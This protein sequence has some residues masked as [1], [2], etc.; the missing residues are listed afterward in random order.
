[1]KI[2]LIGLDTSH[3]IAF[4]EILNKEHKVVCGFPG[5]VP[6]FD[7]SINRVEAFTKRLR[8][9]FGVAIVD[10]PAAVAEQSDIV[11]ITS[12][13]GRAH[14]RFFEEIA[15]FKKPTFIDKPFTTTVADAQ[16]I[17]DLA[18]KNNIP[19]MSSSGLRYIDNLQEAITGEPVVGIDV[20]G[21][22]Q[23]QPTQP[24]LFWYG[25]HGIEMVVAAL[26]VGC[27]RVH[28]TTNHDVDLVV[29]QWADGRVA[30]YRGSR[31]GHNQ[32][33]GVV[34]REKSRCLID[35]TNTKRP[36]VVCMLEAII[37]SL[38]AG[39]SDVPVEQT[40]EIVRIICAANQS[41]ETGQP[42]TL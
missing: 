16:A 32:F 38:S 25:I 30:T 26:G 33:G 10:S 29:M 14:R 35:Y 9:E 17:I 22:M 8:D 36:P 13:D 7:A 20:Y 18:A 15:R 41:R 12:V 4:T 5:A 6:D 37:R 23:I 11:F 42:I 3:V 39:K 21:P 31:K 2:G 28:A 27:R 1:M 40:L 24:G 34:H 19:V